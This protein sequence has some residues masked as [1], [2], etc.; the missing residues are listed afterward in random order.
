MAIIR[1]SFIDAMSWEMAEVY[2][3]ITDQILINLASYFP[4]WK[5][6]NVPKSAFE[7]QAKMLAQMGQVNRDT[8]KIIRQGLKGADKALSGCLEQAIMEAVAKSEPGL[9]KGVREGILKPAGMPIVSPNQTRAFQLY[10]QQAAQKLNL[11]NT[12]MLEST[13]QAYQATVSD[14]T[15]RVQATQ[16]ALDIGTGEVVTGVS[17]WNQALRHSIERMK[18]NGITGFI[19]HGGH[20][21]SAEAYTAMDIRTTVAN[22]ARAAVWETNQDFGNDLYQV[23]YHDGARPLCY[24]W[25][26]KIISANDRSGVT[27]DLDGNEI[28]IIPQSRTSYGEP[29]GLFGINCKH[30]PTPFIPGVSLI[31]GEPQDPEENAKT[32]AESQQQR[33]LE[34]KIREEKRDLLMMKAQ[35]ASP[36]EIKAQRAKIRETDDEIDA[37]CDQTGR[38]R[39]Q[40]REGAYTTRSFPD[41]ETYDVD[42]FKKGQQKVIQAFYQTGGEQRGYTFGELTT[43]EPITPPPPQT[44]PTPVPAEP[45]PV[46]PV[47]NVEQQ[48]TQAQPQVD[49]IESVKLETT[50]FPDSFNKKKTKAFVDAVNATEGTDADVVELFS[51]MG[52][53]VNGK[54]YPVTISYTEDGHQVA[55]Y[56]Y[57]YGGG[58]AKIAVKVPKLDDPE[59][60]RQEI[61]T[62]AHE[63]GHLFDHIHA[64]KGVMSSTFDN[65]ALSNALRNARPMSERV[66]KLIE[67][68][69]SAG[70][71]ASKAAMDAAKVEIDAISA[72]ITKALDDR[73][74]KEYT[75]LAKER[76]KLWKQ[77]EKAA[78]KASRK[79]HN[80]MSAVE[81]IYDAISGGTLRDKTSGLYGH[82]SKYYS[83]N[84]GGENATTETLANYCNLALAY[85]ELFRLMK[86]EQP[87]IWDACSS[88]IKAML[89]R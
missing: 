86:E 14:I 25:Q 35:G 83:G 19:D 73:D 44:P 37:F 13:K 59:F 66:K 3:A 9:L 70:N 50:D 54:S 88:I 82:G 80:G 15:A 43:K 53:Q 38:A 60:L 21:W 40:S 61:G 45:A 39:R 41:P 18:Q 52:E 84:P 16:T 7:Y 49:T 51:K 33:A 24:P 11:V 46:A 81:D 87:E 17:S 31:R 2:G 65:G 29:A 6:S 47:D 1:P 27:Y 30:Y 57:S 26:N 20:R 85:P 67:D 63:W 4:Y 48:A 62:T 64:D 68:A 28:E 12:V 23:S 42:E 22:T 55:D 77:A 10:Y 34:R 74:F 5:S 71:A 58:R 78:S 89:G 36:E 75:R 8:V 32:Y 79:A 69:V 76:E 56:V 72:K